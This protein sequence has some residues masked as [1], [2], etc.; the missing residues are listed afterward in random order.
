MQS[1]Y[2]RPVN[3]DAPRAARKV[4]PIVWT[5]AVALLAACNAAG[6]DAQTPARASKAPHAGDYPF[7]MNDMIDLINRD[8]YAGAAAFLRPRVDMCLA[9]KD[10]AYGARALY[11]NWSLTYE[12]AGDWQGA[13]TTL[14][15][16][17]EVLHDPECAQRLADLESRH[18]F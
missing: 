13:R 18:R 12:N 16:C 4:P 2:T 15:S 10:C 6:T 1:T 3:R 14:Q 17:V 11:H 7:E 8:D 9:S 5:L